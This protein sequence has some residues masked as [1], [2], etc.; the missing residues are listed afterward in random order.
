MFDDAAGCE[1]EPKA[2]LL[3]KTC[4]ANSDIRPRDEFYIALT[5]NLVPEGVEKGR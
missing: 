4:S 3:E 1:R 2:K 5:N